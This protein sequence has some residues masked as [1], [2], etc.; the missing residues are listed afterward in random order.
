MSL[1]STLSPV[2]T[3]LL[4]AGLACAL[5]GG[6]LGLAGTASASVPHVVAPGETLWSIANDNNFTTRALA[7]YNGMDE[8]ALVILGST[9]Q[10]P[11]LAEAQ[12]KL[13]GSSQSSSSASSS[14]SSTASGP[15]P[16]LGAYTV[17]PGDTLSGLAAKSGVSTHQLA[18]MN[19]LEPDALLIIGTALKVP[20][21][22][23]P[24]REPSAA[25]TIAVQAAS[26]AAT[27]ARVTAADV[28]AIASRNGVPP[29]LATA[30]A[31]QESG[32]YNGRISAA[33]A[34]GVMQLMPGTWSHIQ[35]SLSPRKLD[36]TSALDN[37]AA[38]VLYLGHLL[39][40]TGGDPALAV[41]AYYQG[42]SSV[43]RI[44]M[45]AETRLYVANVLALR[46]RFAA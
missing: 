11:T 42:L 35:E 3:L 10:V 4:A 5:I 39:R 27:D 24:A 6:A 26:P 19:G 1:P 31:W 22:S 9:I 36:P 8:D 37:V 7:A 28:R 30:I 44:G 38:G 43:Q 13:G 41:A 21:G 25:P 23:A 20:A 34:R 14:S 40:E 15:P 17:R 12:A 16:A 29:A 33:N 45:L 32:F 46:D 2:R 18:E